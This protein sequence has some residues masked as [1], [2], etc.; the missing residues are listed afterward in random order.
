VLHTDRTGDLVDFAVKAV[1]DDQRIITGIASTPRPDRMGDVIDPLGA[2]FTNPVPLLLGH[3]KNLP[4]GEVTFGAPTPDGIP[5]TAILP[6]IPDP[7]PLQERVDGAW[8]AIKARLL[9]AVSPGYRA[10]REAIT[11]NAFGGC[12]FR[13]TEFLELSLVTVPANADATI[14]TYKA[15]SPL[16]TKPMT[17]IQEQITHWTSERAP[18]VTRMTEMLSPDKTLGEVEQK[19]YDDLAERVAAIDAQTDRLRV[20][21]KAN[22]AKATPLAPTVPGPAKAFSSIRVAPTTPP[23]TAWIRAQ[24]ARIVKKGS[25]HE[26]S[27]YA[28][29]RWPDMPEVALYLKAAVAP[30]TTTAA[31]WAAELTQ[32]RIVDEFVELLR[33]VTAIGKIGLHKVPFN[34]KIPTQTGGGTYGWVGEQKPKPVTKLT[35]SS[36]TVPYHKTAGIVVITEELARLS[37]PSAED[38]VRRDMI[39]G[40][41][42]FVDAAFIDPAKAAVANVS[43]ASIT[44]GTTPITSTGPL[45]DLVAI[46]NAMVAANMPIQNLTYIMS[47][48]NAYV[49]SFQKNANGIPTFP[50]LSA[51]GGS[52]NGMK[53]VTSGAAGTNVIGLI[54][55]L[56]LYADDGG[57]TVDVSR[58]ASL[59]MSDAPMDP[60]DATT[61][62]VSLWQNNCVGLRAEWFITWLKAI[63]GCCR[64]VSGATYTVPAGQL[65]EAPAATSKKGNGA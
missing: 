46:A 28:E 61:V 65:L 60:A 20:L 13:Q 8:Q 16:D 56:V 25:D 59:Q 49:L 27:M 41:T 40:I 57:I 26:A 62:F 32:P 15:A 23:G 55:E 34:T 6:R 52:V 58:E 12:N 29:Q 21:E 43:P 17:T 48:S 53:V 24:C 9:K 19:Q 14:T 39:A 47:P 54:P 33:P 31:G 50:D 30:G 35:F 1:D 51:A 38:L 10:L 64:Y 2:T 63:A 11:P 22:V 5:F 37:S 36:V 44:N 4:V 45:G 18:L 7:G 3:D 42:T